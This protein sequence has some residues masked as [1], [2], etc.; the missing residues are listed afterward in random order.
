VS[1]RRTGKDV[2]F[3]NKIPG[4]RKY[5]LVFLYYLRRFGLPAGLLAALL[6]PLPLAALLL[7]LAALLPLLPISGEAEIVLIGL[8]C[9]VLSYLCRYC[10]H[11]PED[12][13]NWMI[14]LGS[15]ACAVVSN[16]STAPAT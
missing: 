12:R 8:R 5:Q 11:F 1:R 3:V 10:L 2:L 7:A 16:N 13:I 9:S 6:F 4:Y 14:Y 15:M